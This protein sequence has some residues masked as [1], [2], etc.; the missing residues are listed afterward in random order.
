MFDLKEA[1]IQWRDNLAQRETY[2]KSDLDELESHL[3][4]QMEELIGSGLS[5]ESVSG[6][7]G[8]DG[9]GAGMW[10]STGGVVSNST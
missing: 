1:I 6:T 8:N 2:G 3:Q 5:E 9:G 4:E 7:H 10:H